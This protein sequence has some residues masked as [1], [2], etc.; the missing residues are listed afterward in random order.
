[1]AVQL[2]WVNLVTDTFID[3]SLAMEPKEKNLLSGHFERPKK[4]LMDKLMLWRMFLMSAPMI[5][6]TLF[7][8]SK[9]FENNF[10]KA[11]T[12]SFTTIVV[13]QWFN[14]FN[15]RP[16]R[17]RPLYFGFD[18]YPYQNTSLSSKMSRSKKLCGA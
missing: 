14:V 6:G 8:F 7:I 2:I 9:Y 13:F 17:S 18:P 3:V 12:I 15:C 16:L 10:A 1:M 4:Y 11:L 5:I